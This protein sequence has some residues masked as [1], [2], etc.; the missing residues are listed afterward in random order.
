MWQY[1]LGET[2]DEQASLLPPTSYQHYHSLDT[3]SKPVSLPPVYTQP[4]HEQSTTFCSVYNTVLLII[5]LFDCLL[6]YA[7]DHSIIHNR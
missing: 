3:L 4:Q 1:E 6:L 7:D 5:I 2:H